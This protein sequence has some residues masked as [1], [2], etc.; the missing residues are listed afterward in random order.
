MVSRSPAKRS[1][2]AAKPSRARPRR[3]ASPWSIAATLRELVINLRCALR[4]IVLRPVER[5]TWA[6]S[7]AGLIAVVVVSVLLGI[8]SERTFFGADAWFNWNALRGQWLDLPVFLLVGWLAARDAKSRI[9]PLFVP[10]ALFTAALIVEVLLT[11]ALH[12][13]TRIWLRYEYLIWVTA[14]YAWYIWLL[15]IALVLLRRTARL[16]YRRVALAIIPLLAFSVYEVMYPHAS[17]WYELPTLPATADLE[18]RDSPASEEMLS[19]QPRLL[20][21]TLGAVARH[22]RGVTD[23]YFVGF[24]PYAREDVFMQETEVIR[25]LM[26]QRFD[27]RDRSVLLVNNDRA[28]RK[29][30]LATVT[31]LRA[32]LQRIRRRI[33]PNEDVVMIYLTSHGDKE[34]RLSAS[35]APLELDELNPS[36]LKALLDET[37][38]RWRVIVVS[39]CYAGGFIEPLRGPTTLVMT[40]SDATHTSFGCGTA[41]DF[42]YFAKALFDEQLRAMHSFERAFAAALPV[43]RAR[44]RE[45]DYEFSNP[46]FAMGEALRAKLADIERRLAR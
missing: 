15:L 24:A 29:Y 36:V 32:T 22:R 16:T 2:I 14:Y 27:T 46:Q 26:D 5:K 11:V 18:P 41:S 8:A 44:E 30:P 23:L 42:T 38:I 28:L 9:D 3:A 31:N 1:D 21:Q 34:H 43:I 45:K 12:G 20:S 13:A 40:A 39:A 33:D 35:F 19:L 17:L 25:E 37:G 6:V 7:A 4:L 10:I